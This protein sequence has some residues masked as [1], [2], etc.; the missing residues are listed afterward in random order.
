M[1][2]AGLLCKV[3][4]VLPLGVIGSFFLTLLRKRFEQGRR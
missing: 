1:D 4:K 2:S 3:L